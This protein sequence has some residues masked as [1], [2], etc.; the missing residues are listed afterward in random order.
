MRPK[1]SARAESVNN[2]P[3][4]L[5][6]LSELPRW[7]AWREEERV[8]ANGEPTRKKIPYDPNSQEQARIPTDPATWGTR[9][10]AERRWRQLDDGRAGGVGIVLGD[11]G[12]GHHLFGLDLDGCMRSPPD[13]HKV[14]LTRSA[15]AIV[16]RFATYTEVSPS[17]TGVKLFF[18]LE[19]ADIAEIHQLLKGKARKTFAVD[20]HLE[21]AIDRARFYAVTNNRIEGRLRV[22]PPKHIRWLVTEAGPDFQAQHGK[23]ERAPTQRQ[24]RDETASGYGYR[25]FANC[26]AL[27][28][29]FADSCKA[30]L[31]DRGRAGEWA[32]RSDDRQLAH[33]WERA[34]PHRDRD[35]VIP[36][37][38]LKAEQ[39]TARQLQT[40][41]FPPLKYVVPKV[42]V[43]GL[44]ILAG[45]PKIGKSYFMLNVAYAVA[46][47]GTTLGGIECEQ[48]DVLYAALEDYNLRR[49]QSRLRRM[50]CAGEWPK[51]LTIF[52]RMPRL[53]E[54]GLQ[55]I[56]DWI[57][58][59]G[60]PRLVI[61]DTFVKVRPIQREGQNQYQYDYDSASELTELAN[62]AGIAIVIVGHVRKAD[63]EDIYDTVSG[64]LGLTGAVDTIIILIS[65]SKGPELHARGRDL[66]EIVQALSFDR[67]TGRWRLLGPVEQVRQSRARSN[68]LQALEELDRPASPRDIAGLMTNTSVAN[69]SKLL[70]KM[71]S[72]GQLH[73]H[74]HGHYGLHPP[75]E[76]H[77]A[78]QRS[79]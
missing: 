36:E 38:W 33:T 35:F 16:D 21:I 29:S 26:K 76:R 48:G 20:K 15:N 45:K 4:T 60:N 55:V 12:N 34:A 51:H 67:T 59:A 47:G 8:L 11:L 77:H 64:T 22:V 68:I 41:D 32:N 66:E 37:C 78:Q 57:A 52:T 3:E 10:E 53:D 63:A 6:E 40:M 19:D 1:I 58:R 56:K 23:A 14:R 50:G 28:R 73:R 27:R 49:A 5:D 72:D 13:D 17:G 2:A 7:V 25:Y 65:G 69:V 39:M 18:L 44:T 9:A 75:A 54:G 42:I 31:A 74:G 79:E 62:T 61:I 43:E 71:V 24:G 70:T 30:I 46:T